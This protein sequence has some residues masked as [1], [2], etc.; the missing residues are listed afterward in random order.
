MTA[1]EWKEGLEIK[2][3]LT[4]ESRLWTLNSVKLKKV[5]FRLNSFSSHSVFREVIQFSLGQNNLLIIVVGD[6]LSSFFF[7]LSLSLLK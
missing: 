6:F 3:A 4:C 5:L 2:F 1:G 7:L